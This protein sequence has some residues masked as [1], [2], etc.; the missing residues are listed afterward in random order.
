MAAQTHTPAIPSPATLWTKVECRYVCSISVPLVTFP[1]SLPPANNDPNSVRFFV[2]K[3]A[4]WVKASVV[5][6]VTG[7]VGDGGVI[8]DNVVVGTSLTIS[9]VVEDVLLSDIVVVVSHFI[10]TVLISQ[11]SM[12]SL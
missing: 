5:V 1:L 9:V 3:S 2:T 4:T 10:I 12:L 7:G 6:V 8:L 11:E